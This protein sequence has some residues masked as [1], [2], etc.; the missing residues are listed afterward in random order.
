[1]TGNCDHPDF[2]VRAQTIDGKESVAHAL[3]LD[4]VKS[5]DVDKLVFV[6]VDLN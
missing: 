6:T 3:L 5:V 2:L 4:I 1:M